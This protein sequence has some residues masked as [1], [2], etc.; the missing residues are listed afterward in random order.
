M[1]LPIDAP[2]TPDSDQARSWLEEELS[3]AE[4]SDALSPLTRG[5]RSFL[6]FFIDLFSGRGGSAPPIEVVLLII[7]AIVLVVMV[8]VTVLNP[9]RLARSRRGQAVFDS[10]DVTVEDA[11][12]ARTQALRE[13]RI[14][15]AYI[16]A[17]RILVLKLSRSDVLVDSPGLTAHEA[18][19]HAGALLPEQAIALTHHADLFDE[20][21]YG[22]GSATA[23][24]LDDLDQLTDQVASELV[25]VRA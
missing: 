24:D 17:F 2:I 18:S 23:Q 6:R 1:I 22:D 5:I 20:V 3:R 19:N 15:E 21:R 12:L 8:I 16:W 11:Q 4:Y 10:P 14:N 9:V 25:G 7:V 13:G